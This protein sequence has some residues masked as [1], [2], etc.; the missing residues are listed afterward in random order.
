MLAFAAVVLL[1]GCVKVQI[2]EDIGSSGSSDLT[3]SLEPV[4]VSAMGWDKKNPCLDF[5]ANESSKLITDAKCRFDGRKE[6]VTAKFDRKRAGGLT[7]NGAKYRLDLVKALEGFND[8]KSNSVKFSLP[9]E[10]NETQIREARE[11]GFAYDYVV[12]MPGTVTGQS[13]GEIQSDGSVKFDLLELV[14]SDHPYVESETGLGG[15]L[16]G[17]ARE[18]DDESGDTGGDNGAG[19]PCCCIPGLSVLLAAAGAAAAKFVL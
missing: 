19:S 13:G 18:S 2:R 3:M 10:K 12:K 4:N 9:K 15:L 7:I 16:G 1:A 5:K 14:E 6:T 17:S 11:A 8:N